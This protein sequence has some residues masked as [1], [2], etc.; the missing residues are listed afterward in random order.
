MS[1]FRVMKAELVRSFIIMRRY[2]FRTITGMIIGY[3]MLMVLVA[4]FIYSRPGVENAMDR[5]K[6]NPMGATNFILG[7]MIGMFAFGV[8]G[9]FTQGLQSMATTGVLEQLCMSPHG[10]ATNFMAQTMVG[11][12]TSIISSGI[13]V[14]A[15]TWS[16]S[17]GGSGMLHWDTL[18]I[19][20]LLILTFFNLVGFGFMVGGLVLV[21]K[22]VGQVAI[23]VRMGLFAL[24]VFA[25][26]EMMHQPFPIPYMLHMLPITDATIALKYVLIHN[27]MV[28]VGTTEAGEPIMQFSS[29][30]FHSSFYWL[31][32]SCIFWTFL[33]LFVF[34]FLE[35]YSRS[36]GT[37]GSY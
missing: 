16:V 21:F 3:G 8:V 15:V 7:F 36:K 19:L 32:V 23:L 34:R 26:E 27:Q 12:V 24:A 20:I 10:L 4:G 37:L 33:G 6:D 29:V 30:F 35:D 5:F 31:L 1:F 17:R 25:R 2:W 9:M 13:M 18:P 22:Q 11:S 14:Y 28:S